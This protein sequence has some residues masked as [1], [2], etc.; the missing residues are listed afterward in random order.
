M[1]VYKS[2][3]ND[4]GFPLVYIRSQ[5]VFR[6]KAHMSAASDHFAALHR[7]VESIVHFLDNANGGRKEFGEALNTVQMA[8]FRLSHSD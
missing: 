7:L 4:S 8:G 3:R 5:N 1:S 2:R 6:E